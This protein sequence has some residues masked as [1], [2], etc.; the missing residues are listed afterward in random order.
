MDKKKFP[1]WIAAIAVFLI[2]VIM[3]IMMFPIEA[4][5]GP[6]ELPVFEEDEEPLA[7]KTNLT[8][9]P[10]EEYVYN[11]YTGEE[12][13]ENMSF[14]VRERK[15]CHVYLY[16][17]DVEISP[18]VCLDREGNDRTGSNVSYY[19]PYIYM[20]RPWMLAVDEN[21]EWEVNIYAVKNESRTHVFDITYQTLRIDNINGRPAYVVE[22]NTG[23]GLQ[24]IEW[25][26]VEKRILV[27]EEALGTTIELVEMPG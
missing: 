10:G 15:G 3:G 16:T 13:L 25:I 11:Y 4:P 18:G 24:T 17:P 23:E 1:V 6:D 5:T 2:I 27:K 21:W 20:F 19:D 26:D 12:D 7:K 9:E 22:I 8:L 14:I